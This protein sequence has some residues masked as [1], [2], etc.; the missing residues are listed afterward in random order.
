MWYYD[1][2]TILK[3]DP[4]LVK[5]VLLLL[6]FKFGIMNE[7]LT[8]VEE[9][10][11]WASRIGG[12]TRCL[13]YLWIFPLRSEVEYFTLKSFKSF[14][15]IQALKNASLYLWPPLFIKKLVLVFF[16]CVNCFISFTEICK[17]NQH[18]AQIV[19]T[20]VF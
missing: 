2:Y 10:A 8:V 7:V 11:A 5:S 16:F 9:I 13:S 1:V 3:T 6:K 20:C 12:N 14:L 15:Q 17:E 4:I 19:N 18:V